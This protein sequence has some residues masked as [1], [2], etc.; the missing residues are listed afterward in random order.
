MACLS[1][2]ALQQE[3]REVGGSILLVTAAHLSE[4]RKLLHLHRSSMR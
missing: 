2:E 3:N 4:S 1:P